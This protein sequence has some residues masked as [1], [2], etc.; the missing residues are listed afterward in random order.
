MSGRQVADRD[1]LADAEV[2]RVGIV[3]ALGGADDPLGSIV[4]V[5]ELAGGRSGSPDVDERGVGVAGL[6]ALADQGGNHVRAG[7][8]EVVPRPVEVD[9]DQVDAR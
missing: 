9:R 6:D 5:D 2:D 8:V 1:F 7:G 4:D 3:V